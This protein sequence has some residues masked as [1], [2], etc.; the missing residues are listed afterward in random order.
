MDGCLDV[1]DSAIVVAHTEKQASYIHPD[2]AKWN[3]EVW[4]GDYSG[5]THRHFLTDW[6]TPDKVSVELI[7]VANKQYTK[8]QVILT[9]YNEA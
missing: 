4:I 6:G 3:G 5:E 9:S 7:G 8:P 1:Y 2:E